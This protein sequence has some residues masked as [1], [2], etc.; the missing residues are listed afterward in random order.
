[1]AETLGTVAASMS[2]KTR[3]KERRLIG[4][5][6]KYFPGRGRYCKLIYKVE[7]VD[8]WLNCR[9]KRKTDRRRLSHDGET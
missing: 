6:G 2:K 5:M 3:G 7:G 8:H 1:M 4:I 9:R